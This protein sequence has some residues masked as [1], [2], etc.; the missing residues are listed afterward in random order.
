MSVWSIS[1]IAFCMPA[2]VCLGNMCKDLAFQDRASYESV[3]LRSIV[4]VGLVHTS[5][6]MPSYERS[7]FPLFEVVAS[8]IKAHGSS[9]ENIR[10]IACE[11]TGPT[12]SIGANYRH[13]PGAYQACRAPTSPLSQGQQLQLLFVLLCLVG[14]RQH[15]EPM[16][17]SI[18]REEISAEVGNMT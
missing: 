4:R 2:P 17:R 6:L 7:R 1:G 15:L 5:F 10:A 12:V 13:V 9:M 8:K 14:I 18:W 11:P 3:K 16:Q